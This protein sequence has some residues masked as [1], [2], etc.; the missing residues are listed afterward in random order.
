MTT[1]RGT[2]SST[3][4]VIHEDAI[5][6]SADQFTKAPDY[7]FRIGGVRKFFLEAKKPS[8]DVKNDP[9][10]AFQLRR[11]AWS[12]KLSLSVLTDFEELAVYDTRVRP[13]E[14]D[15]PGAARVLL[16]PFREY[17]ER[18]DE[19]AGLLSREAVLRGAFDRFAES[20][21]K[22][23]TQEVDEAFL[24]E[25]EKWRSDLARNLALRNEISQEELNFSVQ[26]IIDRIIFLRICEDRGIEPYGELQALQNGTNVYQRLVELFRRAD[27]KYNSG[28]FHFQEE[29]SRSSAPDR[30]T[31]SLELDDQVLKRISRSLYYPAP[32]EFSVLPADILGQVYEQFLG[33]VIRLTEGGQA[34]VEEK[35]EVRKAGGVY[36]TPPYIVD[37][38]V[39]H[40]IGPLLEG[41]ALAKMG[42][43]NPVRVLDPACGS[44][45]FLL[46]AYQFYGGG[47]DEVREGSGA[48]VVSGGGRRVAANDR[49]A[50]ANTAHTH[51]WG[52]HRSAG[53]G[54]DEALAAVEGSGGRERS[55]AAD[56]NATVQ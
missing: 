23:G 4:D 12:Q 11:Y 53:S 10:P 5:K 22:R 55:N 27:Q 13:V 14:G 9:E 28:L 56:H 54:G 8:T 31:P 44:G 3:K 34:K 18:W 32:Y 15:S 6:V 7:C 24:D 47:S 43:R 30:L 37:Y 25:I 48:E 45:T 46:Q 20:K 19:I 26:A 51:L 21:K 35:P 29:R 52:G 42:G 36:Y 1:S 50:E 41:K 38:I 17:E 39:K 2:R 16:V 49:G 40:T 33:K